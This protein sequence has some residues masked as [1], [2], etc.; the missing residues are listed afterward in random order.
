M[1]EPYW[2]TAGFRGTEEEWLAAAEHFERTGDAQLAKT[3]RK[4]VRKFTPR[5]YRSDKRINLRL[6]GGSIAKLVRL[7]TAEDV[8]DEA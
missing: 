8:P 6:Q 4:G 5:Y 1:I 7:I 2:R 3:I